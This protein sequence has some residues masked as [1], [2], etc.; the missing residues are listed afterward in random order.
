MGLFGCFS[1]PK[2]AAPAAISKAATHPASQEVHVK[3]QEATSNPLA[4]HQGEQPS[5]ASTGPEDL[6]STSPVLQVPAPV[7]EASKDC[8]DQPAVRPGAAAGSST[9]DSQF[10][11]PS[12][13]AADPASTSTEA[14]GGSSSKPAAQPAPTAAAPAPPGPTTAAHSLKLSSTNTLCQSNLQLCRPEELLSDI[15]DLSFI[16]NGSF[17]AVFKGEGT[18]GGAARCIL[19]ACRAASVSSFASVMIQRCAAPE[20]ARPSVPHRRLMAG[21]KG[22]G[23]VCCVGHPQLK[24]RHAARVGARPAPQPPERELPST[25]QA[26]AAAQECM[27]AMGWWRLPR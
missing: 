9:G 4:D 13:D 1:A 12:A 26:F 8:S 7:A 15:K 22:G 27:S 25:G 6:P 19:P 17:A 3:E 21:R 2:P 24:Q 10:T 20:A 5:L 14:A 16:G 23:Q 18:G 11:P